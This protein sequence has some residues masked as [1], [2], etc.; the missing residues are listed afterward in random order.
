MNL[1][2]VLM[3]VAVALVTGCASTPA[4]V[5]G[6]HLTVPT[7]GELPPPT[8]AD[9][10][11]ASRPYQVGPFDELSVSVFG[12]PELSSREV[13][14]DASGRISLPLV[15]AIEASGKTPQ[16][17]EVQI[18]QALRG[19]YV[20]D[21]QVTVNLVETVSQ[22][23]TVEGEVEVPGLYPVVGRMTLLRAIATARGLTDDASLRDVV[24]FRTVE[25]Q[26][27]A[28]LYNLD[29][30]RR[31]TYADP[32]IYASDV[33]VVGE[34]SARRLFQTVLQTAPLLTTPLILLLQ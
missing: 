28:A 14:A 18:E 4:L 33:V 20:R 7:G 1:R 22:V 29:S 15:G 31:G 13:Q 6:A 27:M 12:I 11:A 17:L 26:K 3:A 23:V 9:I 10:T 5:P 2:C 30:I 25:G 21:P 34:S 24:I 8:G 16:E 19:R 32:D